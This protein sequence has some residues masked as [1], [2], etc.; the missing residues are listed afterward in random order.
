[1]ESFFDQR[2]DTS[3]VPA[4]VPPLEVVCGHTAVFAE[5]GAEVFGQRLNLLPSHWRV[6]VCDVLPQQLQTPLG[7]FE[8][9]IEEQA[10]CLAEA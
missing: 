7:R 10:A 1:M 8:K 4:V 2:G 6:L 9:N 5:I 3:Q